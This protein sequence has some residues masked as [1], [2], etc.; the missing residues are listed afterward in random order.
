MAHLNAWFFGRAIVIIIFIVFEN[1]KHFLAIGEF[2]SNWD[3]HTTLSH[4]SFG[5]DK[6]NDKYKIFYNEFEFEAFIEFLMTGTLITFVGQPDFNEIFNTL[7]LGICHRRKLYHLDW[8]TNKPSTSPHHY[9]CV[10]GTRITC[11]VCVWVR[12]HTCKWQPFL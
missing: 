10:W 1:D 4:N 9:V 12:T 5:Y 11:T 6:T 3:R 2:P 7:N 8:W